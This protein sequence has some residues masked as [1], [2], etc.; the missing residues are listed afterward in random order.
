M[1]IENDQETIG[2]DNTPLES[3]HGELG[4]ARMLVT[5]LERLSV[6]SVWAHRASGLRGSLLRVLESID[7]PLR[8]GDRDWAALDIQHLHNLIDQGSWILE[9]AAREIKGDEDKGPISES[10]RPGH[11]PP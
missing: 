9:N 7:I 5:R 1:L 10:Q 6:D 3:L 2:K 8:Q 4:Y 11:L